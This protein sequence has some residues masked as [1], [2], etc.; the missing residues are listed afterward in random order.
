MNNNTR[1]HTRFYH[2]PKE[3]DT[4]KYMFQPHIRKKKHTVFLE[5]EGNNPSKSGT[6][7]E[8]AREAGPNLT[9]YLFPLCEK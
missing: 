7:S 2:K 4:L 9:E 3:E 6:I 5:S 8:I 1:K